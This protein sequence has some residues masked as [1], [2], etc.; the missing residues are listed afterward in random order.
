LKYRNALILVFLIILADQALKIFIKTHF[1]NGDEVKMA[2][3]W[4]KLHFIENDGMAYGMKIFGGVFG[5]LVLTSFRLVAVIAGFY[6]IYWL[7]KKNQTKIVV[8]CFSLI[9][10]GAFG[11]L[12]D[13]L[14]YGLIFTDSP[15]SC[16]SGYYENMTNMMAQHNTAFVSQWTPIGKGY[17]A[18]MQ[19]RVVDMLYFPIIDIRQ[20][21]TWLPFV[22][23]K[24]FVFFEPV[25]NIADASISVGVFTLLLRVYVAEPIAHIRKN[26]TANVNVGGN[27]G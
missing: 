19:G 6:L 7:I 10:A 2:G 25:F 24:P 18:F 20:M 13:S 3:N 1:V 26:K 4:F 23:G 12:I 21:P 15:Y 9:L 8:I 11:N 14:I 16:L 22:G 17:G 5:K 27:K